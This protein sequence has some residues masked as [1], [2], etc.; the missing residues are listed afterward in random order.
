MPL[1]GEVVSHPLIDHDPLIVRN[2]KRPTVAIKE[3]SHRERRRVDAQDRGVGNRRCRE[4][5]RCR[6]ADLIDEE[7]QRP[8]PAKRPE[9]LRG[10]PVDL[11]REQE[12]AAREPKRPPGH[13]LEIQAIVFERGKDR[14]PDRFWI[15]VSYGKR[16]IG[17]IPP[18]EHLLRCGERHKRHPPGDLGGA[19]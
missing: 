18:A 4:P 7:R 19:E 1:G 2:R 12:P 13:L 3:A 9:H 14:L 5:R 6:H 8:L 16:G 15:D 11:R 17:D 10:G